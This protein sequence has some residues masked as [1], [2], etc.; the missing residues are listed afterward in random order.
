[1]KWSIGL[2]LAPCLVFGVSV[3]QAE[4]KMRT[5]QGATVGER[6]PADIDSLTCYDTTAGMVWIPAG[7]V[8]LG[9]WN[10]QD[11]A[12]QPVHDF[13]VE[14]FHIDRYEVTN[15]KYQAFIDAGGYTTEAYWN[16]AG[17]PWMNYF[18]FTL[19]N[20]WDQPS[21][22]GGG[23]AGNEQFPVSGVSWFEA[24]A[25][26]RWAGGR[27]PTEAEWEKAARGGCE[28][29]GDPDQCDDADTPTYPWGEEFYP[30]NANFLFSGDPYDYGYDPNN[31]DVPNGWT[32]P[33]GY[34]DGTNHDGYQTIDSPS[35]YGLYDVIGNVAEWTSSRFE[36]Y[37][38]AL[39]DGHYR[40]LPP[41]GYQDDAWVTR[42]GHAWWVFG[43]GLYFECAH[44]SAWYPEERYN[45]F[46]FRCAMTGPSF[47]DDG[48]V[49]TDDFG[50]RDWGC[51]HTDN[52]TPCDD[53]NACTTG[54]ACGGGVCNPGGP[55]NCDDGQCCTLDACNPATG[56]SYTANTT[57]PVFASQPSLG[58][59]VLWPP[60]HGYADFNVANTGAAATSQCGIAAIN[61]ASCDSSQAENSVGTG[62]GNSTRDCVCAPG[63]LSVRAERD[64]SCSPT[65][66]VYG[67]RLVA[68]D[69]CGNS[70]T[71]NT[72]DVGVW[73]D[74]SQAPSGATIVHANGGQNEART[75]A[76]GTYGAGCGAGSANTNGTI[77]DH[78]DAD[79]EMEI[80]QY[81]A[82]TVDDLR[83]EKATGG[84]V[85]LT[86][87]L[88]HEAG[89]I[90]TRFH[91][92]RLDP[93]TLFWTK[94]AEVTKQTKS[95]LDPILNDAVGC[96]YKVTAV[97]K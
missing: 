94:I 80:S 30:S 32:T 50:D 43:D 45:D 97:I 33:V 40:E 10:W 51:V 49:C 25:Y 23:V 64:G 3:S 35:P 89:A 15:G 83:V 78:S 58:N 68:V 55:T 7:N 79:P 84:N 73:H 77:H 20:F 38:Y 41:Q 95:Y 14:G 17:W 46:G 71:S 93:V 24:D 56:C 90:V 26:C 72:F 82:V 29:H 52:T 61:F 11:P 2:I 47:C 27:L 60:N 9:S 53:G 6:A 5:H 39:D 48:N 44:R 19:P 28:T 37:P 16:P 75:G 54:D 21:Y 12:S 88:D 69:V 85:N 70:T 66:R 31:P 91:V 36:A 63:L 57:A 4:S 13:F 18:G 81:A 87:Y 59:T 22:H 86:W 42:G 96:Q 1:M 62:D 92:Y 76:N 65:G 34:Y 74:R 8:R 67:S